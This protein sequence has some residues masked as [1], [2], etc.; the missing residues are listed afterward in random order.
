MV[1]VRAYGPLR[2]RKFPGRFKGAVEIETYLPMFQIN[3]PSF[4]NIKSLQQARNKKNRH[5]KNYLEYHF[6]YDI[7]E[8][9]EFS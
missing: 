7:E 6:V 4:C 1:I 5:D 9:D 3:R 2:P 8:K